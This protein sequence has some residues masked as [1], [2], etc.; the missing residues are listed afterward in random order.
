ME[1]NRISIKNILT[2][3][4]FWIAFFF[5]IRLAGI[6]NP[7]LE[8]AHN[9]RQSVTNMVARNFLESQSNIMYPMIDMAGEKSGIIGTEFPLF[10][11][12]IYLFS[13]IFGYTHW[14]GR[15]INLCVSSA[16]LYFFFKIIRTLVDKRTAFNAAMVLATSVWFAYSRKIMPDTFSISLLII[17]LYYA[18]VFLKEGK[19]A[20][21]FL[22]FVF[23]T[24]GMLSKIPALSLFSVLA[25]L[26]FSKEVNIQRKTAIFS[27]AA[28]SIAVVC[29]WYFYW[30]PHLIA[31]YHYQLYFPKG[32]REGIQEILPLVP[33]ALE[34]FYFSSLSSYVAFT[35]FIMGLVLVIKSKNKLLLLSTG[36]ITITFLLFI[37]KTGVVFPQHSY[38][39]IPFT[40]IMALLAG[41]F[42][43]HIPIKYQYLLLVVIAIEGIANQQHDFFINKSQVYKLSLEETTDRII[44]RDNLIIINGGQSPQDIYFSNRKGWTTENTNITNLSYL[45]SLTKLGARYLIIDKSDF[46]QN[47]P[48]YKAVYSDSNYVIYKLFSTNQTDEATDT[49]KNF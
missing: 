36:I 41:Y 26:I 12:L 15:F 34:K 39:I 31:T 23:C 8:V 37:I 5:I 24:L 40:P 9:W 18:V 17:G 2:D 38:Y 13:Y 48:F 44:P 46:N 21:L 30:V 20:G 47:L 27:A 28:I 3:I 33:E 45:D 7:P 11:Y 25:I 29:L 16:G 1:L 6:T 42:I 4:R 49:S 32:I 35:C 43:T 19:K 22:F 14:V 10:N